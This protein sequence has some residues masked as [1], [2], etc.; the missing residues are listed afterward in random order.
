MLLVVAMLPGVTM[1][2]VVAM[3]VADVMCSAWQL[4]GS[5]CSAEFSD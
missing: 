3:T 1:L 2:P 5:V 4:K